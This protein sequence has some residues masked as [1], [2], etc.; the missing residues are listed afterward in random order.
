MQHQ[1]I[2]VGG[3]H[4]SG[5]TP[6]ARL[7]G[8]HAQITGLTNT[9][10]PEDEGQH[11]QDVYPKIR[12]HGGMSRFAH[13]HAAHLTETS[14]LVT[15]ES[16][17]RLLRSWA[18]YWDLSRPFLLEKSPGNLIKFRFLQEL[19]PQSYFIAMVRHPVVAALAMRKWNPRPIARNGRLRVSLARTVAHW[20]AAHRLLREDLPHL[21]R[22]RV[23]C[24]EQLVADPEAELRKLQH[25]LGLD[26]PLPARSVRRGCN[27]Q[28]AAVWDAMQN[29]GVAARRQY[30]K[31][32]RMPLAEA[33][34]YGYDISNLVRV[35]VPH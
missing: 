33:A 20:E 4:R 19:F 23:V 10:V 5:T 13:T 30:H 22:V 29:G 7:L 31:I 28:Y 32:L 3:L 34:A 17:E 25:F 26:G 9:G 12:E 18:P 27:D 11:L 16:G 35:P 2:F 6:L 15:S 1:H 21:R 8:E 24:Y 14:P